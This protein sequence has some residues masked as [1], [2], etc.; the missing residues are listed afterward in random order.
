MFS[1][2]RDG[3]AAGQSVPHVH[4]HILPRRFS[5]F[6]GNNDEVYPLLEASEAGLNEGM[7]KAPAFK[8][9][10]DEDRPPRTLKEMEK[11]ARWLEGLFKEEGT[12]E[13]GKED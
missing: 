2:S 9:D 10:A 11:E 5:D 12:N 4:V 8:V 7:K 3:P 1:L 6:G 13:G